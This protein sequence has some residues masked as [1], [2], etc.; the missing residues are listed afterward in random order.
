MKKFILIVEDEGELAQSLEVKLE[1]AGFS[2]KIVGNG[3]EA[4]EN[5][6]LYSFDLILL[7][8]LTPHLQGVGVLEW[9]HEE[10]INIPV[11]ILT[12]LDERKSRKETLQAGAK[13]YYIKSE[14]S[15]ESIIEEI[16]DYFKKDT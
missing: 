14:T 2:S 10:N 8:L 5:I 3:K 13:K 7:D 16:R 15:L 4:I 12:N 9:M 11:F 1:R 6:K